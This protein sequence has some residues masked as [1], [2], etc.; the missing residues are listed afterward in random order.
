M[1]KEQKLYELMDFFEWDRETLL[2]KIEEAKKCFFC[3][4]DRAIEL[5][6][7]GRALFKKGPRRGR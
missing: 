7:A 6:L 2:S 3:E 4:E 5:M 1:T